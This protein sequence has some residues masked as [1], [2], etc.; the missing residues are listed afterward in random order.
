M[1][2]VCE[3]CEGKGYFV[4][5]DFM[6]AKQYREKCPKC[7]GTGVIQEAQKNGIRVG[8]IICETYFWQMLQNSKPVSTLEIRIRPVMSAEGKPLFKRVAPLS[9]IAIPR[10]YIEI[11]RMNTK[12]KY[13]KQGI[14]HKLLEH[15]IGDPKIEY[16]YTNWDDSTGD[17]RNFLLKRGFVQ[18]GDKLIY[19]KPVK[20]VKKDEESSGVVLD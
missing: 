16:A 11:V 4:K 10:V 6:Q 3:N 17:G 14:M 18:E 20:P 15:A 19:R 8:K 9:K 13:R 7:N 5:I 1:A 12:P 2:D